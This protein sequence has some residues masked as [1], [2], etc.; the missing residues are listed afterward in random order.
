MIK[1]LKRKFILIAMIS[2]LLVILLLLGA[3]N[4]LNIHQM[5]RRNNGAIQML[6]DN[7]GR[8]PKFKKKDEPHQGNPR[9]GFQMNPETPFET[10]Y[11]I[12]KTDEHG[13]VSEIDTSHIAAVTSEDAK[14]YANVIL[15]KGK[16][17]GYEGVYRYAIVKQAN[18]YMLIFLD[19]RIQIQMAKNFLIT[20]IGMSLF[21]LL[22]M[23][24]LVSFFS[25]RA[26]KPI[27]EN[28]EKQK[29]FITDAGHEIK[30]PIAIISADVDVL[31]LTEGNNEWIE[32]IRNQTTR[33]DKLVKNLLMLSKM[34]ETHI[35][36]SFSDFNL[37]ETV[38]ESANAFKAVANMQGK[39]FLLDVHPNIKIYGEESSIRQLVSILIDNA[40]KYANERGTIKITLSSYKKGS[41]LEVDNSTEDINEVN[42]NRLFDRFYR[43]DSSRSRDTGGYGIG[44]SI[45]KS[46]VEAH[47]GKISVKSE[48]GKSVCFIV[49]F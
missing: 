20:S 24:F 41:K 38:Y 31:E 30:T 32:S 22:L 12:V 25:K 39:E 14:N 21:T 15:K 45:A 26:I 4:G 16:E 29:Q 2:L 34:E 40:I 9:Q 8:F 5:E 36:L 7:Q 18:G 11:F 23:F 44:L 43:D 35:K 17:N 13:G 49:I 27:I 1:K 33:L 46:I 6:S 10:R 42:L 48:D 37:S 47:N 19:C 3:I 28:T